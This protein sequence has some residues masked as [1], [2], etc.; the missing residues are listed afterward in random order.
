MAR[1]RR[2]LNPWESGTDSQNGNEHFCRVGKTLLQNTTFCQL[3]ASARLLY[4]CM[5]EACAGQR[6][7]TFTKSDC[8]K[9]G[10]ARQTFIR[11]RD[12][13]LEVGLIEVF[14]CGRNTRTANKYRFTDRWK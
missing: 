10:I 7:F 8:E 4:I 2:R 5:I 6:E 12:S 11:A 14:E 1:K 13:L 9:Y 3:T